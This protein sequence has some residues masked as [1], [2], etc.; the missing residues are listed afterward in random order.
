MKRPTNHS[1]RGIAMLVVL[2]AL[3]L[4]SAIG[5]AMMFSM[6]SE[7]GVNSG[8]RQSNLSYFAARSGVEEMRDR[9][10]I[11]V[12]SGGIS[13][14]LPAVPIGLA[15][16]VVYL[17]NPLGSE[18]VAPWDSTNPYFDD[19]LCHQTANH[20]A[21]GIV[22]SPADPSKPC[23]VSGNSVPTT[24]GWHVDKTAESMPGSA[25]VPYKWAR[26][27]LK[28]GMSSSPWCI[29]GYSNVPGSGSCAPQPGPPAGGPSADQVCYNGKNE[30]VLA[31][32]TPIEVPGRTQGVS[33]P[34]QLAPAMAMFEGGSSGHSN[35][36]HSSTS[37]SSSSS[38]AG[39]S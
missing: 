26:I 24:V 12:A 5:L 36:G 3:I 9:M 34:S 21:T 30:F 18:T 25:Y 28:L 33:L 2:F 39:S 16:G 11:P 38:T 32:S 27:Y 4:V 35:S 23:A 1:E 29:L 8:F 15:G 14:I 22:N 20:S 6:N 31:S 37:T 7:T 10:R 17:T 13:D 19:E